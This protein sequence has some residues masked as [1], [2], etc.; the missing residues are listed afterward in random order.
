MF[1]S[2][3]W[4]KLKALHLRHRLF[5]G[6]ILKRNCAVRTLGDPQG[7]CQ[8]NICPTG[9]GRDS[10][11]YSGGVGDDVSFEH[12][13]VKYFGCQVVLFDPSPIGLKTMA[14]AE[15]KIP[16]FRFL[17]V[18]LAAHDGTLRLG[19]PRPG[20]QSWFERKDG[21]GM[22]VACASLTSAMKQNGHDRIDLLKLDI[23]GSEYEVIDDLL[24]NRLAVPQVC[25]EYH[26]GILP[27]ISRARTLWSILR[28][29]ARGYRL[30][31]LAAN[32]HTFVRFS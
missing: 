13:L 27:S 18:A 26:H 7:F 20:D 31:D 21:E 10:V 4:R 2:A 24:K 22:E 16:Q 23:E 6:L 1:M 11:V 30:I 17:P 3:L 19:A 28:L 25:V 14:L 8:W 12:D 9:L 15:N 5:Y 32:N 29:E